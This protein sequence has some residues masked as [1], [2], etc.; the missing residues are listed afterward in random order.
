MPLAGH[1]VVTFAKIL[2]SHIFALEMVTKM[3][4]VS[5]RDVALKTL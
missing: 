1:Q 5:L 2:V 3:V 4:L